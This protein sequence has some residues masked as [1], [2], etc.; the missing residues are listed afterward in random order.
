VVDTLPAGVQLQ[1][2]TAGAQQNGRMLTWRLGTLAPDA[3]KKLAVNVR[4]QD[5][6]SFTN[7]V[8]ARAFCAEEV[9]AEATTEVSGIPAILL[10]VV[11]VNDPVEV[12]QNTTYVVTVTNQGSATGKNVTVVCTLEEEM[13]FVSGT[14]RTNVTSQG[15]K[16]NLA[17]VTSLAPGAQAT[18]N[19][20]VKANAAGDVRFSVEMTE[21]QLTRPVRETEATNFYE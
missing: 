3:S 19:I 12:G 1:S 15:N 11:D 18:W 7:T 16:V 13:E 5:A 8:T 21:D 10:E 20:V 17:P 9:S 6:G 14:G 2:A 4:P